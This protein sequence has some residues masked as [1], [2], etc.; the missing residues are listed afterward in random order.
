[1]L[2]FV[3]L[4]YFHWFHTVISSQACFTGEKH[5]GQVG[6]TDAHEIHDCDGFCSG[7]T[8]FIFYYEVSYNAPL[9]SIVHSFYKQESTMY[10]RKCLTCELRGRD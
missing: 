10:L 3:K 6:F 4:E 5:G 7:S 8:N 2:F 9:P 1:M